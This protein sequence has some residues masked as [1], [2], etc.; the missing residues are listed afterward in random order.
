MANAGTSN[1]LISV[2][3]K[4]VSAFSD[5]LR[6]MT[7]VQE[8]A[9]K[10][11]TFKV[12]I[13]A[14]SLATIE[15]Q[16]AEAVKRGLTDVSPAGIDFQG[17]ENGVA[18][19]TA[20][21]AETGHKQAQ[22]RATSPRRARSFKDFSELK[23]ALEDEVRLTEAAEKKK[24]AARRKRGG[25]GPSSM[26]AS[27]D[28]YLKELTR[29]LA[30]GIRINVEQLNRSFGTIADNFAA[31][32]NTHITS[33]TSKLDIKSVIEAMSE[34]QRFQA[35][36]LKGAFRP[37]R[38]GVL[39]AAGVL[40]N[41]G[42]TP[43][44]KSLA[45]QHL[46][47]T[48]KHLKDMGLLDRIEKDTRQE[49]IELRKRLARMTKEELA[50]RTS[51]LTSSVQAQKGG[52]QS[53]QDPQ[54][55]V[56]GRAVPLA[57]VQQA[58]SGQG[59]LENL[60][61]MFAE[62]DFDAA[63]IQHMLTKYTANPALQGVLYNR[64]TK[65]SVGA[66][67]KGLQAKIDKL[68]QVKA[69][70]YLQSQKILK[71][72]PTG[73][74]SG[75]D[76]K[77]DLDQFKSWEQKADT[78]NAAAGE[79]RR[80]MRV[81]EA[82][83]VMLVRN[84][85]TAK[86][87]LKRLQD[88]SRSWDKE[89]LL[90][91]HLQGPRG[92]S[93]VPRLS[94]NQI[95]ENVSG[96]EFSHV[97][98]GGK[99]LFPPGSA[100]AKAAR[101]FQG[102]N[103]F[104]GRGGVFT[105]Y[106]E[107][108]MFLLEQGMAESTKKGDK[109]RYNR[110]QKQ[111]EFTGEYHYGPFQGH[112]LLAKAL[113]PAN[114]AKRT[115]TST[116]QALG[117]L[118]PGVEHTGYDVG[119][120]GSH[121]TNFAKIDF[122][123][124]AAGIKI[125]TD[126]L[127]SMEERLRKATDKSSGQTVRAVAAIE[128]ERVKKE[129][130][131]IEQGANVATAHARGVEANAKVVNADKKLTYR[132]RKEE[133]KRN[134]ATQLAVEEARKERQ[135]GVEERRLERE[136]MRASMKAL[137]TTG[138]AG[139]SRLGLALSQAGVPLGMGMTNAQLEKALVQ[140]VASTARQQAKIAELRA[141]KA[142]YAGIGMSTSGID[143]QL[144]ARGARLD[145]SGEEF[146]NLL[147]HAGK[148]MPETWGKRF[149]A[150]EAL[151]QFQNMQYKRTRIA[152]DLAKVQELR[153]STMDPLVAA[154]T[155]LWAEAQAARQRLGV[156]GGEAQAAKRAGELR[157]EQHAMVNGLKGQVGK[158]HE[159]EASMTR[160]GN[161][162]DF[163]G[164]KMKS[165]MAYM[166]IGFVFYRMAGG[167][168]AA[169]KEV[170]ELEHV[171][172]ELQ[173]LMRGQ[174]VGDMLEIKS[175]ILETARQYGLDIKGVAEVAKAFTQLGLSPAEASKETRAAALGGAALN[176]T[177]EQTAQIMIAAR[178]LTE[179]EM[180]GLDVIDRIAAV[181]RVSETTGKG[182]RVS[183]EDL[184]TVIERVG[185]LAQ[186][187]QPNKLGSVTA[188]DMLLGMQSTILT[189]TQGV[190]GA[191]TAAAL[192][193][194]MSSIMRPSTQKQLQGKFGIELG[195]PEGGLRPMGD[196]F[197]LV[198]ERY[199]Q[200]K[201]EGSEK[202]SALLSVFGGS[203]QGR[204]LAPL[205]ENFDEAMQTAIESSEAFGQAEKRAAL[206]V[207]TLQN[208][209]KGLG[210]AFTGF[211]DALLR[212]TGIIGGTHGPL[213]TA[214]NA[215]AGMSKNPQ[216]W[217]LGISGLSVGASYGGA[218][219][220]RT[221]A[222]AMAAGTG[223]AAMLGL[224]RLLTGMLIGSGIVA[225]V[226][227]I[228][229]AAFAAYNFI[230]RDRKPTELELGRERFGET[231]KTHNLTPE[232]LSHRTIAANRLAQERT[233]ELLGKSG[234]FTGVDTD[235]EA[236]ATFSRVF[237]GLMEGAVPDLKKI[238]DPAERLNQAF[239]LLRESMEEIDRTART[240]LFQS[241]ILARMEAR[242]NI[243]AERTNFETHS[244]TNPDYKPYTETLRIIQRGDQ[245]KL[246][247]LKQGRLST[248]SG[249]ATAVSATTELMANVANTQGG[250]LP[251][252]GLGG[253]WKDR[254]LE[255]LIGYG[256]QRSQ[257]EAMKGMGGLVGYDY[258][259]ARRTS[260]RGLVEGVER[261]IAEAKGDL[262]RTKEQ[263]VMAEWSSMDT[264]DLAARTADAG[265]LKKLSDADRALVLK[266]EAKASFIS[267]MDNAEA[268]IAAFQKDKT[269]LGS[270]PPDLQKLLAELVTGQSFKT[271]DDAT[272]H[273]SKSLGL[274]SGIRAVA[275][276][277]AEEGERLV[278]AKEQTIKLLENE[279]DLHVSILEHVQRRAQ[280]N[281]E[282]GIARAELAGVGAGFGS[283]QSDILSR[284]ADE[285]NRIRQQ[286][287]YERA[288]I[289]AD[290]EMSD[291]RKV[292]LQDQSQIQE[293][294]KALVAQE[295]ANLDAERLQVMAQ[296]DVERDRTNNAKTML[297]GATSGLSGALGQNFMSG[298]AGGPALE[299]ITRPLISGLQQKLADN[300]VDSWFGPDGIFGGKMM[301]L[302][303]VDTL[304]DQ[305][306][307][308]RQ[309]YLRNLG[310]ALTGEVTAVR[311]AASG[312]SL[313]A[314]ASNVSVGEARTRM[315]E[316]ENSKS[317]A[318]LPGAAA[319]PAISL[320]G[321]G[322]G[323]GVAGLTAVAAA[324][325]MAFRQKY[326]SEFAY[327]QRVRREWKGQPIPP[328]QRGM[329]VLDP[330][331]RE[332]MG[333]LMADAAKRGWNVQIL[334]TQ[335]TQERQDAI[336]ANTNNTN[337]LDSNHLLGRALDIKINGRDLTTEQRLWLDQRNVGLIG[338]PDVSKQPRGSFVDLNHIQFPLSRRENRRRRQALREGQAAVVMGP[339][340]APLVT[341]TQDT[342]FGFGTL[343]AGYN[344]TAGASSIDPLINL[345]GG[346][347]QI[348]PRQ[349]E[350]TL[351]GMPGMP[352]MSPLPAAV[353]PTL[354]KWKTRSGL[355]PKPTVKERWAQV[356]DQAA[357]MAALQGGML[358]G[359]ALNSD[360]GLGG[361]R[362]GRNKGYNYASEGGAVGGM[363][364]SVFGAPGALVGSLLGS[365]LG[366]LIA[367]KR[368]REDPHAQSLEKI[369]R[370]TR[371]SVTA[372][373]N[374]TRMIDL[375]SRML[376]VPTTFKYPSYAIAAGGGGG[377]GTPNSVQNHFE[378]TVNGTSD[379]R[380]TA[381]LVVAQL[382]SELRGQGTFTSRR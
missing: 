190:G 28:R 20:R 370:N 214:S 352:G 363:L 259:G 299:T 83:P 244:K 18:A 8:R 167:I 339:T 103:S 9:A 382:R 148:M 380:Q 263:L 200:Y 182:R 66:N 5:L 15:Q 158:H 105:P 94:P 45:R 142:Q 227:G 191:Q 185:P 353:L 194:A 152:A 301:D 283:R 357:M 128:K 197:Q 369:E 60:L 91:E 101:E 243:I 364:G 62:G 124:I 72:S 137:A 235:P 96:A 64:P 178:E 242:G 114:I 6:Y 116:A 85:T 169:V 276:E 35:A 81:A 100:E 209:M 89:T 140:N 87:A 1:F 278:V 275:K 262:I 37:G 219:L 338:P 215:I 207:D 77:E 362:M 174:S 141:Q 228:A 99:S 258:A 11:A 161:L 184:T 210:N 133:Q 10:G 358:L 374:Q 230:T 329:G 232:E 39:E 377:G 75:F 316:L 86:E 160:Q 130:A 55:L 52:V 238:A 33:M 204:Q 260:S 144:M 177:P 379:A 188:M 17:Y 2:H 24:E 22:A 68:E 71:S 175:S 40:R 36:G 211:M 323:T 156:F 92:R 192:A 168:A 305:E 93:R 208:R 273:L 108:Q 331:V 285:V 76:R 213:R 122:A 171:M 270:L 181:M 46:N 308:M 195:R 166:G 180:T 82:E 121:L 90:A 125:T 373:E 317:L 359:G 281:R 206:E 302:F 240:P 381:D 229:L 267:K 246:T 236:R 340:L 170:V 343:G 261:A 47:E 279:R 330:D 138:A 255:V 321:S 212:N 48:G 139:G 249:A 350:D 264:E 69:Q 341:P 309:S 80:Q 131:L 120:L 269:L 265:D 44:A 16:V 328:A 247:Q 53:R 41:P 159:I 12:G 49:E 250:K 58:R 78:A 296:I 151:Q 203:R 225:A 292:F 335:R 30:G 266:S 349:I 245:N 304:L 344:F 109:K 150:T 319:L 102:L 289:E 42:H 254:I 31:K 147:G 4:K 111:Y 237:L 65:A 347:S 314:V 132:E 136:R 98:E 251:V 298:W 223:R 32:L 126:A 287:L 129:K 123:G 356:G 51:L 268:V 205:L 226:I 63:N 3:L 282:S 186:S 70:A 378:I 74:P 97:W 233:G 164:N 284:G 367:K 346:L 333:H 61:K 79:L 50:K 7:Q 318:L 25:Q 239:G 366:G 216:A 293:D 56:R 307:V 127:A 312:G 306:V 248:R 231:A 371:E 119:A 272:K 135:F 324:G 176:M 286:G 300:F 295:T 376:G 193:F 348:S 355:I 14:T 23:T 372:I 43:E 294:R 274:I 59:E 165:I 34:F 67:R 334:E 271:E 88:A 257:Q 54:I 155:P 345:S 297:R 113:G 310:L 290:P 354:T 241:E 29:A 179:G 154:S 288:L 146:L 173:G 172:A 73:K 163:I 253:A 365:M 196:I 104:Y 325:P 199:K 26:N 326:E 252:V 153:E 112:Q 118:T 149:P 218:A 13:A 327:R 277:E 21:G 351:P 57:A 143:S 332:K 202:A 189:R 375:G 117:T 256:S 183:P 115:S 162:F 134:A 222:S 106:N 313:T 27:D 187:L 280:L 291:P 303:S 342:R 38:E 311:S 198:A 315:A 220:A 337:T 224:A 157:E 19:A 336:F 201:S 221:A 107:Q 145:Y 360:R 110:L 95:M 234:L 361:M 320:I 322:S 84:K 217:T 368:P